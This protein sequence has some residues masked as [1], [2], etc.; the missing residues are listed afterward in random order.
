MM[1][2]VCVYNLSS[3]EASAAEEIGCV[4]KILIHDHGEPAVGNDL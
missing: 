2:Q 3:W 4:F 1:V